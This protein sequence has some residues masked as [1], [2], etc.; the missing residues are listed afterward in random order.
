VVHEPLTASVIRTLVAVTV[1]DVL[2]FPCAVMH[3]PTAS[4][5]DVVAAVAVILVADP[6]VA[7][8]LT[9]VAVVLDEPN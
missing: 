3:L 4:E 6:T 7:V 2:V 8:L 1:P 9:V 5:L